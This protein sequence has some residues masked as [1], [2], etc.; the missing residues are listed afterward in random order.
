MMGLEKGFLFFFTILI[1]NP[2]GMSILE[3]CLPKGL[4]KDIK[5]GSCMRKKAAKNDLMAKP[6]E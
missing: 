5:S 4:H 6:R 3:S 1:P 2:L